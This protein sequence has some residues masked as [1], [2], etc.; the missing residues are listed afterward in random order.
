MC[1]CVMFNNNNNI[2]KY[3]FYF[4]AWAN[5][6]PLNSARVCRLAVPH[7]RCFMILTLILAAHGQWATFSETITTE[8]CSSKHR[9]VQLAPW[10]VQT[11]TCLCWR[12]K[13][14]Y[15]HF[16]LLEIW[17]LTK[18]G[19]NSYIHS[20]SLQ[21]KWVSFVVTIKLLEMNLEEILTN[22]TM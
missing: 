7:L 6:K 17:L 9:K 11:Q 14:T 12:D 21:G 16:P 22:F 2:M 3:S 5:S 8:L 4:D 1:S 13:H 10:L 18:S 15:Q 20:D 19:D